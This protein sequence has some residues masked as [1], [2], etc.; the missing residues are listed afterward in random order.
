M[1]KIASQNSEQSGMSKINEAVIFKE[2]TKDEG[3]NDEMRHPDT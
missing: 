2:L 3:T 1:I